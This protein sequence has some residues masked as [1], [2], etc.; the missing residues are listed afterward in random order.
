VAGLLK[1]ARIAGSVLPG[2]LRNDAIERNEAIGQQILAKSRVAGRVNGRGG[3][4]VENDFV[5]A[6]RG[7]KAQDNVEPGGRLCG[8]RCELDEEI[9]ILGF[10]ALRVSDRGL[11]AQVADL[12]VAIRLGHRE[13]EVDRGPSGLGREMSLIDKGEGARGRKSRG[14]CLHGGTNS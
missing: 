13:P 7:G 14:I 3:V 2:E 10:A 11:D 9:A 6:A 8:R 1:V 4:R 12:L 5:F